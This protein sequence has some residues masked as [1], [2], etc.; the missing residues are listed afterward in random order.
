MI[1]ALPALLL[2]ALLAFTVKEQGSREPLVIGEPGGEMTAEE[3]GAP[4]V[5]DLG[6]DGTGGG[7]SSGEDAAGEERNRKKA[8]GKTSRPGSGKRN[9]EPYRHD[10][11]SPGAFIRR[12]F[13]LWPAGM[14]PSLPVQG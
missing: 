10:M 12:F 2:L 11:G 6:T 14:H 13:V 9:G 4:L 3:T 8:L 5:I 7:D 1:L